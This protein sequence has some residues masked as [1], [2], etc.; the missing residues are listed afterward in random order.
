VKRSKGVTIN[1]IV[2]LVAS[3]AAFI[4]LLFLL[5]NGIWSA[6]ALPPEDS[7]VAAIFTS[8]LDVILMA[9]SSWGV[10]TAIGL[11]RLRAWA[12]TCSVV[13][14]ALISLL[15]VLSFLIF[16]AMLLATRNSAPHPQI[17]FTT[18]AIASSYGLIAIYCGWWAY[19][20]QTRFV[21]QQ[22]GVKEYVPGVAA[23]VFVPPP[24]AQIILPPVAVASAKPSGR[25]VIITII[26]V[27]F[28]I[29]AGGLAISLPVYP[30]LHTPVPFFGFLLSGWPV[31]FTMLVIGTLSGAAG[32]GLLKMKLWAR[33]LS[34]YFLAFGVLNSLATV[35]RPGSMARLEDAMVVMQWSFVPSQP[36]MESLQA[37]TRAM[38]QAWFRIFM[39]ASL[40]FGVILGVAQIWFLVARKQAFIDANQSPA[41]NS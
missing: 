20:F 33:T 11:L 30:V 32:I 22:F 3:A 26:A 14:S 18:I 37:T 34:I 35:L 31:P 10:A 9:F 19:F 1:A 29:G 36:G 38:F 24:P 4:G 25:P 5:V 12:R 21:K 13:F 39:P 28:F 8:F 2:L 40:I 41:V 16:G 27:M 15:I 6:A 17:G 7:R 23:P